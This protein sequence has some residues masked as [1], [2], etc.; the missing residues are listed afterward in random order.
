ME[1]TIRKV[2]ET[3]GVE[4]MK[5]SAGSGKTFSL[6]REYIRLLMTPDKDGRRNER[7]YR[8]ILAVTFTNKATG[9]MKA[10]IISEL[11]HLN[12]APEKSG[13]KDYLMEECGFKTTDELKKCAGKLLSAI[14]NDYGSFSVSTIDKFF[15]TTLRAFS[16]EIGQFSEYQI[17]LDKDALVSEAAARVLENISEKD[18]PMLKWLSDSVIGSLEE[19]EGYRIDRILNE[20]AEGYLSESYVESVNKLGIDEE[21]AFSEDNIRNLNDRCRKV[22][23]DFR[24]DYVDAVRNAVR[25]A[26]E[27]PAFN[28]TILKTLNGLEPNFVEKGKINVTASIVSAVDDPSKCFSGKSKPIEAFTPVSEA[29]GRVVELAGDRQKEFN[30]ARLLSRQAY[31]FV[32]AKQLK[33]RFAELLKEKNVLSIDDTN[34]ILRDIIAGSDAPFIYEKT[35]LRY[36]HFLLDEFQDT[37]RVQWDNFLPLLQN[38]IAEGCYNLIV[39]DVKQSI[40]RWRNSDWKILSEE[41]SSCLDRVVENPLDN[42]FRSAEN[43]VEFNNAF[44]R[45]LAD[46]MDSQLARGDSRI[47]QIYSG[48]RQNVKKDFKGWVETT[49]CEGQDIAE[50]VVLAVQDALGRGFSKKDIAVIVRVNRQGAEMA[51]ALLAAG[52]D[53]VTNDSLLIGSGETVRRL[54]AQLYAFND[55]EDKAHSLYAGSFDRAKLANADSLTD[56][57]EE[58]LRQSGTVG[59]DLYVLAFMDLLREFVER[60]GNSLDAFLKYW[61]EEGARRSVSSPEGSDAVT[62]ITIH[63]V[64]GLDYP[65]VVLPLQKKGSFMKS[66]ARYWEMPETDGT[67]FAD[68]EKAL[69]HVGLSSESEK[70]LFSENYRRERQMAFIDAANLWYVA[71]TRASQSMHIIGPKPSDRKS[72]T[73][74]EFSTMAEALHMFIMDRP[75]IFTAIDPLADGSSDEHFVF[76]EKGMKHVSGKNE[77]EGPETIELRWTSGSGNTS[78]TRLKISS[79]SKD[80]FS[81]D[82]DTGVS[83]SNRLRGTVL[84]KIMEGVHVIEDLHEETMK[85]VASGNLDESQGIEAEKML[86]DAIAGVTDRGWFSPDVRIIRE[87]GIILRPE[88]MIDKDMTKKADRVVVFGDHV[89]IIDYKFGDEKSSYRKQIINYKHLYEKMGYK[90]VNAYLWY[91]GE[92]NKVEQVTE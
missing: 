17:E 48:V 34:T 12:A 23:R 5:A 58:L 15:Q 56:M 2:H 29:L 32:V 78:G 57:A 91:I 51:K 4:V 18:S 82:G 75:D 59:D 89:D 66:D 20:F 30:T 11:E 84:H 10:R 80:F 49:W 52:I 53:V 69:Y 74:T 68:V 13:Y 50:N 63:K 90:N 87:R 16:R 88:D 27:Y 67:A 35:G 60:N 7:A 1:E 81:P 45:E 79:D 39:G 62:I 55:S 37:A 25:I 6:A 3:G 44:Y 46:Q 72:G 41:V 9:E 19:G 26:E 92:E 64:K 76:G 28:K 47:G 38:S 40:Y 43:V 24:K 36:N 70:N 77:K 22:I 61:E 33:E 54:V 83:A 71:M 65:Y 42:N 31:I 21:K 14:L 85:A 73:W 86:A 8:H